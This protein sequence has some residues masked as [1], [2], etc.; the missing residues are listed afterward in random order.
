MGTRF[1]SWRTIAII[2]FQRG[3]SCYSSDP[4]SGHC[5]IWAFANLTSLPAAPFRFAHNFLKCD[6]WR[7]HSQVTQSGWLY[8]VTGGQTTPYPFSGQPVCGGDGSL[9]AFDWHRSTSTQYGKTKEYTDRRIFA[10]YLLWAFR[11]SGYCEQSVSTH[12]WQ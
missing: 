8:I 5:G 2:D 4:I 1:F 12:L 6:Q 3:P 10:P 11:Y 7:S 9:H